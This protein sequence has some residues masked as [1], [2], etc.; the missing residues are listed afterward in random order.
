MKC[1]QC[2]APTDVK[3]TRMTPNNNVLRRRE[4]F[5]GHKFKTEE[6]PQPERKTNHEKEN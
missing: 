5:N 3:D 4:C 6:K 1:P 2:N